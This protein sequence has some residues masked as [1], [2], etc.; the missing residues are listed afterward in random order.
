MSLG[1]TYSESDQIGEEGQRLVALT[2]TQLGYIWHDRRVDLGIDGEIELVDPVRRSASNVHVL[3][4]SKATAGRLPAET[5]DSFHFLLDAADVAYWRGA[6]NRVIVVCSRPRTGEIWWAPV[7][8]AEPPPPGR[9]SWRLDFNKHRDRLDAD[10]AGRLLSWASDGLSGQEV[11]GRQR[12]A[13]TLSTN[14][15]RIEELPQQIFFGP[16]WKPNVRQLGP[17]LRDRGYFRS[18]WIVRGGVIYSFAR[19]EMGGL[20]DFLDGGFE[21]IDTLEWVRSK[22]VDTLSMFTDLLRQALLQQEYRKLRYH[23]AKRL[24][25]FRSPRDGRDAVRVKVAANKPGRTVFQRYYKDDERTEPKDCRHYA[26]AVRFVHTDVGWAAEINPTYHFTFD[27]RRDLPWGQD[28]VKGMKKIEKNAAV[29][30]LMQFW[31]EY[32]ARPSA[33]GEH[34]RPLL[35]GGLIALGVGIGINDKDWQPPGDD[36]QANGRSDCGQQELWR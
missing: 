30:G 29:R 21:A 4:Q 24:F 6:S 31:S 14:L 11:S 13:E 7:E 27:G 36:L 25:V 10:G 22:D 8:R 5:E 12:R 35:F 3:V 1:K 9:K 23:S 19:P 26:A 34:D 33:F 16:T 17:A 28:R 32:L 18:D 2:V 20:E 15:L